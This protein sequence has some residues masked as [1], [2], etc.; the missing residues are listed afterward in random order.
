MRGWVFP[1]TT[2]AKDFQFWGD[3]V[4]WGVELVRLGAELEGFGVTRRGGTSIG[5][6]CSPCST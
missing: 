3:V 6:V 1:A 2:A 4:D 5:G